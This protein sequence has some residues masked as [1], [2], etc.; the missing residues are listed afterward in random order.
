MKNFDVQQV[1]EKYG[2]ENIRVFGPGHDTQITFPYFNIERRWVQYKLVEKT[3]KLTENYKI[4]L[5]RVD[6][7][8]EDNIRY[9]L[10]DFNSL[11]MDGV[12]NVYQ[13]TPDGYGALY[14]KLDR[15]KEKEESIWRKII[16][17]FTFSG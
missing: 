7:L 10:S 11:V 14:K 17:R 15:I 8:C 12:Y 6:T 1:I 2:I 16:K 4:E 9:Y 13:T 5:Q 3:Y